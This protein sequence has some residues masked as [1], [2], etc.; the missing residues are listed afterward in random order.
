MIN[1]IFSIL[2]IIFIF[3]NSFSEFCIV[4]CIICSLFF[5]HF[6]QFL[7]S[8]GLFLSQEIFIHWRTFIVSMYKLKVVSQKRLNF[9]CFIRFSVHLSHRWFLHVPLLLSSN[10]FSL[11]LVCI[12]LK[13]F[14]NFFLHIICKMRTFTLNFCSLCVVNLRAIWLAVSVRVVHFLSFCSV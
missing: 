2:V 6:I 7:L 14:R 13:I 5:S 12:S 4:F 3:M 8:I 9:S 10:C 11:L 1:R